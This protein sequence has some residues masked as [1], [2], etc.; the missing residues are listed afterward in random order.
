[1]GSAQVR[2]DRRSSCN[3]HGQLWFFRNGTSQFSSKAQDR[4]AESVRCRDN[5]SS[6]DRTGNLSRR[7]STAH[8]R[9]HLGDI[10]AKHND[11]KELIRDRRNRRL[12]DLDDES[13]AA[14][15]IDELRCIALLK[16]RQFVTA[17]ERK[18]V[19]RA[20]SAAIRLY[21]LRRA[22]GICEGCDQPAPFRRPDGTDYL[23]PHHTT[24]L[25]DE[26]PDHPEKV[27]ALCP[28]CHRHAHSGE[29]AIKFN[30]RLIKKLTKLEPR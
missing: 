2:R 3:L 19:Y 25:S 26:G 22:N 5:G 4:L 30:A 29:D 15:N 11:I 18:V 1:M 13:L 28:N 9:T 10:P 20:R 14:A 21:V 12:P 6:T 27:I 8:S 16:S 24:K 17:K 7:N 23:E